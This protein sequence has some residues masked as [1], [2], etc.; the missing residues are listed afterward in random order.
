MAPV[1]VMDG[2]MSDPFENFKKTLEL[3]KVNDDTYSIWRQAAEEVKNIYPTIEDFTKNRSKIEEL[4]PI[5]FAEVDAAI[6]NSANYNDFLEKITEADSN[7]TTEVKW[8]QKDYDDT[9]LQINRNI[10]DRLYKIKIYAYLSASVQDCRLF[11]QNSDTWRPYLGDIAIESN[12]ISAIRND[13]LTHK[14][15]FKDVL[16]A[17]ITEAVNQNKNSD[18]DLIA[19]ATAGGTSAGGTSTETS[20]SAAGGTSTVTSVGAADGDGDTP[21]AQQGLT[22]PPATLA[23]KATKKR[24]DLQAMAAIQSGPGGS[25]RKKSELHYDDL[26]YEG[27]AIDKRKRYK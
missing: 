20:V 19:G 26:T 4:L 2:S 3:I 5:S 16:K 6:Y 8:S 17:R 10:A 18:T 27:H 25:H 11:I 12:V 13:M 24:K 7:Y 1:S 21:A 9:K 23:P 15:K 14:E 22:S